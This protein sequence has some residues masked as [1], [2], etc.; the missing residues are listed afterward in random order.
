MN[1]ATAEKP[2]PIKMEKVESSQI[3]ERGYDAATNTL[4]IKFKKG[5]TYL[6]RDFTAKH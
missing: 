6:Y 1:T 2:A 3:A 5:G 4:A